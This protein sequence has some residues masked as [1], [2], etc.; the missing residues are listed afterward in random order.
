MYNRRVEK[1]TALAK[2]LTYGKSRSYDNYPRLSER[3]VD[4]EMKLVHRGSPTKEY[5]LFA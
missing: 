5:F 2:F 1:D 3:Y 4:V